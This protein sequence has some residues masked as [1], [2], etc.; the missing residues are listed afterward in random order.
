MGVLV[1]RARIGVYALAAQDTSRHQGAAFLSHSHMSASPLTMQCANIMVTADGHV[2][3]ADFG[4]S[5]RLSHTMAKHNTFVGTPF[6][7][8]PEVI[9]QVSCHPCQCDAALYLPCCYLVLRMAVLFKILCL[10]DNYDGRADVW[11]LGIRHVYYP[12]AAISALFHSSQ[13][14]RNGGAASSA[15][16]LKVAPVPTLTKALCNSLVL[17]HP[18]KVL[19]LVPKQPPPTLSD[20]SAWSPLFSDFLKYLL[21]HFCCIFSDSLCMFCLVKKQ[22]DRPTAPQ[23]LQ[24]T[25]H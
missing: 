25:L 22:E 6:W 3:L 23:L 19:F 20:P 9:M 2:K 1:L 11:S 4:V 5:A 16:G 12:L 24:V 8:A 13:C 10:Q 17:S 15:Y 14:N 7:M 18:M 21:L